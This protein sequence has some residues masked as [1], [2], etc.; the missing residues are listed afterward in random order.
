MQF[1]TSP[2]CFEF[3]RFFMPEVYEPLA[4]GRAQRIPLVIDPPMI[5]IPKG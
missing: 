1:R 5:F 4:G 2:T 3:A